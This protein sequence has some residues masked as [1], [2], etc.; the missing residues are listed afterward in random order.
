MKKGAIA[1]GAGLVL[2]LMIFL[3]SRSAPVQKYTGALQKI[4][5]VLTLMERT[6]GLIGEQGQDLDRIMQAWESAEKEIASLNKVV[7]DQNGIILKLEQ[8]LSI[9]QKKTEDLIAN[10]PPMSSIEPKDM[11][12]CLHELNSARLTANKWKEVSEYR[13]EEIAVIRAINARQGIIIQT[14]QEIIQT[15]STHIAEFHE[16]QSAII[17]RANSTALVGVM[18]GTGAGLLIASGMTPVGIGVAAA[19]LVFIIIK[20]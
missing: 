2:I 19:G 5:M 17:A 16:A 10:I 4:D 20:N 6:Q 8:D 18:T 3:I 14:Q 15:Q 12:E 1:I 13:L 7:S 11:E 9:Q